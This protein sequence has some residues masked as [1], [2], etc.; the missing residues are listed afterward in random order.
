MLTKKEPPKNENK[1]T[2]SVANST[3]AV[4]SPSSVVKH[5][6]SHG[7]P[8]KVASEKKAAG[9]TKITVK[10]DVGFS[11]QLYIRGS[12]SNLNWN[13]GQKLTNVK[14]DEWVW[15]TDANFNQCEFKVLINDQ[16]FEKG[17]NHWLHNG[18]SVV[19]TPNF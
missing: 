14:A 4:K 11:N 9:K 15:E 10:Y 12:G 3:P 1:P 2:K 16:I 7:V 13:K 17:E 8:A 18:A 6:E 5:G 19:Y